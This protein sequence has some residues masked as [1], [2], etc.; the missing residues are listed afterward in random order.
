[1]IYARIDQDSDKDGGE[2]ILFFNYEDPRFDYFYN[3]WEEQ[4]QG[5]YSYAFEF[6]AEEGFIPVSETFFYKP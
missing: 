5:Q 6:L 3:K 2:G 4:E 1:M